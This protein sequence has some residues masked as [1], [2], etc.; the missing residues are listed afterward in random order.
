MSE[1]SAIEKCA[2][3]RSAAREFKRV[4]DLEARG[5]P[6]LAALAAEL[7]PLFAR[8]ERGEVQPPAAGLYRSPHFHPDDPQY[9]A[10]SA[11]A[12]TEFSRAESAFRSAL[13]DWRSRPWYPK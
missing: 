8:I 5:V 4:L 6:V 1:M 10:Y 9:G 11:F 13:E 3:L 2:L 7:Q 12:D